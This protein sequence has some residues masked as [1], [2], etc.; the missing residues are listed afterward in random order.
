[1]KRHIITP[2]PNLDAAMKSIGFDFYQAEGIPY[3]YEGAY[4]E[5]TAREIDELELAAN[6]LHDMCRQAVQHVIDHRLYPLFGIEPELV[7]L[8]EGSWGKSMQHP[9]LYGRFDFIYDGNSPPKMLEYNADTPTSLFEASIVQWYW[10]EALFPDFAERGG[11]FNSLHESMVA[12]WRQ[13]LLGQRDRNLYF[14]CLTP[15]PEDET[16]TKYIA[17]T[18]CEAGWEGQF[19]P[20]QDI[21]WNDDASEFRDLGE[22]RIGRLFKLYPWEWLAREQYGRNVIASEINIIEPAW[23]MI[24]SN[25]NIL[26]VLWEL[27][28]GHENLLEAH[29]S[30]RPFEGR[31]YVSKAA[32]GREGSNVTIYDESHTII[33]SADG[34]YADS[35]LIYQEFCEPPL[36]DGAIRPNL[37][38]WIVG[39]TAHGMGVRE[40]DNLIVGN[41]SRFV[42]HIFR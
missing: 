25:K 13:L 34:A 12:R 1:M 24:L 32:L 16:T 21:G 7:P 18:A 27:Y 5:F 10:L 39:G 23:K 35:G 4:Y 42:P 22:R 20:L 11:Q 2:R 41:M 17:S 14:T 26:P 29:S 9:S 38:V 40:D 28:P 36:Y 33:A 30:P 3:W 6:T 8:I 15:Q 31:A 19:I 37:G